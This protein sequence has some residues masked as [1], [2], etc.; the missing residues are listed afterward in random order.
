MN[1]IVAGLVCFLS[2]SAFAAES[3]LGLNYDLRGPYDV[4][5]PVLPG[6][7]A[8]SDREVGQIY[9]DS[10]AG[11]FKGINSSGAPD[12]F[13]AGTGIP[14]T[15]GTSNERIERATITA[16][17]GSTCTVSNEGSDW[18][19]TTTPSSIGVCTVAINSGIFDSSSTPVC[20]ASAANY[21]GYPEDNLVVA[22][23]SSVAYNTLT[24]RT[25][26]FANADDSANLF[27]GPIN[28]ICVGRRP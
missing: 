25:G 26:R 5:A 22:W 24:L 2:V 7:P 6:D 19:G 27:D 15:T 14:V 20:T 28:V 3:R 18:L 17:N 13:S 8:S 10:S 12:V 23:F 11:Q 16:T 9:Y 4:V 1:K 21:S